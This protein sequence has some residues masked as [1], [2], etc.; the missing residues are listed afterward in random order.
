MTPD[1][2]PRIQPLLE[3]NRLARQNAEDAIV[4]SMFEAGF[5]SSEPVEA[6]STW[7]LV[8][9]AAVASFLIANAE[10]LVPFIGQQGFLVCGGFL[11]LSCLF[12]MVSRVLALKCRIQ[13]QTG[14]AVRKTFAEHL[15]R[16]MEEERKIEE[17]AAVWGIT[18]ETGVRLERILAEFF[19]PL[20]KWVAWLAQRQ[21]KKYRGDPQIGYIPIV[22]SMQWQGLFAAMQ[23]M[24][25][26]IFLVVGFGYAAAKPMPSVERTPSSKP[27]AAVHVDR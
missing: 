14:I 8:G 9:A 16:H 20:P 23:A 17:S 3:W 24:A 27:A 15:A 25:F 7:L 11:C 4:S 10:K 5:Q 26:F 12:G 21:L 22:K 2:E 6:F 1:T 19:K 18:L 13:M